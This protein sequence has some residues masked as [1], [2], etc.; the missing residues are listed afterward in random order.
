VRHQVEDL[1][2]A[3][4]AVVLEAALVVLAA[5]G[6]PHGALG[7]WPWILQLPGIIL[8]VYPPGG[9]YF[10][11][12]VVVGAMVQAGLWFALLRLTIRWRR[13]ARIRS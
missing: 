10:A 11:L 4:L 12:R 5:F 2:L 3:V 6:G 7:G 8:V 1:K 13:A 9:D